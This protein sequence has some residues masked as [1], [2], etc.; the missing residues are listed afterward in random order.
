MRTRFMINQ[1]FNDDCFNVLPLI[2]SQSIDLILCDLPYGKTNLK[3]AV[4]LPY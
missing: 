1:L 4:P 3:W 2:E